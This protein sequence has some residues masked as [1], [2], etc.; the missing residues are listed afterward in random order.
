MVLQR[1][2][3]GTGIGAV[4]KLQ[5]VDVLQLS[6]LRASV[7]E[8]VQH[9]LW[10]HVEHLVV[11]SGA[12]QSELSGHRNVGKLLLKAQDVAT[13]LLDAVLVKSANVGG[14]RGH[15]V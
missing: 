2:L 7:H 14:P 9:L 4:Q 6:E 3:G 11:L 1:L 12:V 15:D 8:L 5:G 13:H 10:S